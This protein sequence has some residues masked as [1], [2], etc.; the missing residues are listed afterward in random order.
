[1]ALSGSLPARATTFA[2]AWPA[3]GVSIGPIS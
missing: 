3:A 2:R 1:M